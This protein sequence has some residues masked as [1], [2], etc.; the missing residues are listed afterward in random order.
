MRINTNPKITIGLPTYNRA[1][2]LSSCVNSVIESNYEN[3]ELIISDD[4]SSDTTEKFAQALLKLD[5]RIKYYRQPNRILLP[6]N[7]NIICS[8]ASSDLILF[9]EDDVL[10]DKDCLTNLVITYNELLSKKKVGA[11]TPR[12]ITSGQIPSNNPSLDIVSVNRWT[13]L[14]QANFDY[15]CN[16]PMKILLGHA[17]SLISKQAWKDIDGYEESRY[18]GTNFREETDLYFRM[19]QKGYEIFFEPK[20]IIYHNTHNTG[21]CRPSN[22][23]KGNIYY[24]KNHIVFLLRFY[25]IRTIYMIPAFCIYLIYRLIRS[26]Q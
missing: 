19:A 8:L 14:L 13:G 16:E 20:A 26:V 24:A 17:C 21:G 12:M 23:L 9:I 11:I 5:D 10:I 7:R 3:W 18:G 1:E 25:K 6:K 2:L 4:C 15:S 22:R